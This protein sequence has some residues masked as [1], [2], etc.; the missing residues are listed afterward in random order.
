MTKTP[1]RLSSR[2]ALV[3]L[4]LAVALPGQLAAAQGCPGDLVPNGAVNGV[5]LGVLLSYWGPRTADPF[6]VASDIDGN[7][8]VNGADLGLLLSGWGNC[9]G[10]PDWATLVEYAPDP[11]V[12]TDPA[13]RAAIT[14]TGLAWRVRDT[15]TQIEFVLIPPGTFNMGCSA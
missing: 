3:A 9:P 15:A 2:I 10:V 4:A 1:G 5:D 14:A 7:G 6:S 8:D 12:V 13:L 11:T